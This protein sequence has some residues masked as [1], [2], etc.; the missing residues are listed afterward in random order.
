MRCPMIVGSAACAMCNCAENVLSSLSYVQKTCCP[1][2][3]INQLCSEI[4]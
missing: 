1:M 2:T 4:E 3:P